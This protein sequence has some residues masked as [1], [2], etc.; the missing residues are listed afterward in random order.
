GGVAGAVAHA[1]RRED[2]RRPAGDVAAPAGVG[3]AAAGHPRPPWGPSRDLRALPPA[4]AQTRG[5]TATELGRPPLPE[6]RHPLRQVVAGARPVEG[7]LELLARRAV[8]GQ[9]V[10]GDRERR[11]RGDLAGPPEGRVEVAKSL[12]EPEPVSV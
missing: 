1:A 2:R 7:G 3:A 8:Q 10:P 11:Q 4:I 5:S 12:H 6:G 9:L